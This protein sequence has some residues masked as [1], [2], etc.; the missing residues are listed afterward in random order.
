MKLIFIVGLQKSGTSLLNRLLMQ[1]PTVTNPFLPE[2][3]F[4]WGDDPPFTP[5]AKPCGDIYQKYQG[6]MGHFISAV[7]FDPLDQQLLMQR[8]SEAAISTPVLMNKNPYN[9][10][11]IKWLKTIFPTCKIVALIRNPLANVFSLLKKHE[12]NSSSDQWWGVKPKNWNALISSNKTEQVS[13]QW[14]TVNQSLVNDFEDIDYLLN[15]AD[16]CSH[17]EQHLNSILKL[18]SQNYTE[19]LHS[20]LTCMDSEYKTGGSLESK[21][22]LL[23]QTNQFNIPEQTQIEIQPLSADQIEVINSYTQ[24]LYSE[25]NQMRNTASID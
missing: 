3:K 22:K 2:G 7:D 20:P 10:V 17:P 4:F 1:Q 13:K 25:L 21:N 12:N 6:K 23:R 5:T 16:L 15:Y 19:M 14:K 8:I 9:T 24:V 11:R 18:V